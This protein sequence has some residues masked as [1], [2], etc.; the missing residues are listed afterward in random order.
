METDAIQNIQTAAA[1]GPDTNSYQ[2]QE[3]QTREQLLSCI[4]SLKARISGLE[5]LEGEHERVEQAL[6]KALREWEETFNATRDSIML[7]DR[8]YCIVQANHSASRF[9]G[10]PLSSII[11]Q[12]SY[13]LL[14][15]TELP[16]PN[17]PLV[18]ARK[19]N[20][21]EETELYLPKK[22]TWVVASADPV[23]DDNGD[24][25]Y[26][27]YILRDITYRKKSEQTLAKLNQDLSKTVKEL[28]TSNQEH[29]NFAHIIAHDLK[30]PLRGIGSVADRLIRIYSEKLDKDGIDQ[31]RLLIIRARRMSD[32]IDGILRFAEIGYVCE[33]R[34]NVDVNPLLM[35]I[36]SEIV[37]PENIEVV[38]QPN[39]PAVYAERLR[40]KQIFQNLLSNAIKYLDKPKGLIKIG[41]EEETG[42]WKFSVQD[43]GCGIKEK[44]FEKIFEIFQ[45]LVP[46]DKT[47][48][49]GIGLTIVKKIVE[50]YG[51]K[52]T[53]TSNVGEGSTFSFTLPKVNIQGD[54]KCHY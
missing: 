45:T 39:M 19:T 28:E 10:K 1:A 35:E 32:F 37:I 25:A 11:G 17:C 40:L 27:V 29:R 41:C 42:F 3:Q 30:S 4:R 46:R 53:V 54:Q 52:V 18:I 20:K 6:I 48:S 21:H 2:Y 14:H 5:R 8:D 33:E 44:Y 16:P 51:G 31:L 9:F 49:T 23:M 15:E 7:V 22:D 47:E 50:M 43:N 12:P 36:I 38:I 13:T 26:Y 24:T 34:H